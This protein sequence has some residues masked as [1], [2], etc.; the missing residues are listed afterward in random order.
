MKGLARKQRTMGTMGITAR[1][2]QPGSVT[3]ETMRRD[4]T[5]ESASRLSRSG[6]PHGCKSPSTQPCHT[7]VG[8]WAGSSGD[9]DD[10]GQAVQRCYRKLACL[11]LS[12]GNFENKGLFQGSS[13]FGALQRGVLAPDLSALLWAHSTALRLGSSRRGEPEQLKN[14][15]LGPTSAGF[16]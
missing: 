15:W 2:S 5:I 1:G 12:E 13:S 10:D 8:H 9:G 7:P 4:R 16:I 14:R 11:H 3:K 6:K